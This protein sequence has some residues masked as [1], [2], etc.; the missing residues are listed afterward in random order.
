M[1]GD[2]PSGFEV[3]GQGDDMKVK[4]LGPYRIGEAEKE[5]V[6]DSSVKLRAGTL[7]D[8]VGDLQILLK[9]NAEPDVVAQQ[10]KGIQELLER[11][12]EDIGFTENNEIIVNGDNSQP[13]D[14]V[15]TL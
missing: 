4:N 14:P 2:F 12:K 7:S 6:W 13:S 10:V 5:A 1:S 9:D 15:V 3:T 11:I 8:L